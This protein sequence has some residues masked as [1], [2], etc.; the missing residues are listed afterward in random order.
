MSIKYGD[1]F[2]SLI[3]L[4]FSDVSSRYNEDEATIT[5]EM[6]TNNNVITFEHYRY[7]KFYKDYDE[8]VS[9]AEAFNKSQEDIVNDYN[10]KNGTNFKYK[11]PSLISK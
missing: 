1:L 2:S 5:E 7:G 8:A 6:R 4:T 3:T 11:Y 10:N 9:V